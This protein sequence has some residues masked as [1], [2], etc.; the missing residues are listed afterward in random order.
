MMTTTIDRYHSYDR[1]RRG[2]IVCCQPENRLVR[3]LPGAH[4]LQAPLVVDVDEWCVS[5]HEVV[6]MKYIRDP[7]T[8]IYPR[9]TNICFI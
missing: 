7:F 4:Q 1:G 9:S 3:V 6:L 8:S 5:A 2:Q